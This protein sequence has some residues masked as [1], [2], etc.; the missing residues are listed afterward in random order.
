MS[1]QYDRLGP[2]TV[3]LT[4][5]FPLGFPGG[6]AGK[7]PACNAGDLGSIPGSGRSPGEGKGYALQD[8]G[9]ENPMAS[10]SLTRLRLSP[11]RFPEIVGLRA[12]LG[13]R[14]N[15]FIYKFS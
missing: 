2:F 14:H 12:G 5:R 8:S 13:S 4:P 6:S 10:Q 11:P 9:L 7:E 1:P 3:G 15:E